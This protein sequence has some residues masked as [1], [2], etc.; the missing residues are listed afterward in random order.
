MLPGLGEGIAG[1]EQHRGTLE[2]EVGASSH[3]VVIVAIEEDVAVLANAAL[4]PFAAG[5]E[6]GGKWRAFLWIAAHPIMVGLGFLLL[7]FVFVLWCAEHLVVCNLCN[8]GIV[9]EPFLACVVAV[10]VAGIGHRGGAHHSITVAASPDV[11]NA[12]VEARFEFRA[13]VSFEFPRGFPLGTSGLKGVAR[14]AR[15]QAVLPDEPFF[16]TESGLLGMGS[17]PLA[18][19]GLFFL[20]AK[21]G[22]VLA[23]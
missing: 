15:D 12:A 13:R 16:G 17:D 8:H 22:I 1:R 5:T 10:F 3:L 4:V 14:V 19:L 6:E 11:P 20:V 21:V 9:L 2:V 18:R 7:R 23:R